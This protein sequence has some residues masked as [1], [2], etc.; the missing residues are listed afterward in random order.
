MG[1]RYLCWLCAGMI[2]VVWLLYCMGGERV[3]PELRPSVSEENFREREGVEVQGR[4]SDKAEKNGAFTIRLKDVIFNGKLVSKEEIIVYFEEGSLSRVPE[5][6]EDI[7]VSGKIRF[8]QEP[9]NPGNFNQKFYYQKQNIHAS[10]YKAKLEGGIGKSSDIVSWVKEKL[11]KIRRAAVL[12]AVKHMGQEKGGLLCAMLVGERGLVD[13]ELSVLYQRSQIAHLFTVSGLHVSFFG[14]GLYKILRKMGLPIVLCAVTASVCLSAYVILVGAGVSAVRALVMF[15]MRMGAQISGRVYDG[16]TSLSMAAIVTLFRQPLV[17]W[18]A[19]FLL[20]FGAV[21]GIY[22]ILPFFQSE[23]E[24]KEESKQ[25][26]ILK[27]GMLTALGVNGMIL[28]MTLYFYYEFAPYS[29]LWN[30]PVIAVS[31][32]VLGTGFM[33]TVFGMLAGGRGKIFGWMAS[34][35]FKVTDAGFQFYE[36]GSRLLLELPGSHMIVGQPKL[37]QIV[38]YYV[39]LGIAL[40]IV[41]KRTE[42]RRTAVRTLPIILLAMCILFFPQEKKGQ[43][44]VTMLD[45]GQGDCFFIRGPENTTYLIDGG[46][47]SVSKVGKYRIESFLKSKGIG[48]LDY[49]FVSHGD[50]DHISGVEELLA[51]QSMGIQV[52]NLVLPTEEVWDTSLKRLAIQALDAGTSVRVIEQG[53]HIQ[54]QEL[55]LTCLWPG[56]NYEGETGNAA[57][58]VLGLSYKEF[59]MIFMGDI[60]KEAE[61]GLADWMKRNK[62]KCPQRYEVLKA[63]HHG[64]KSS[65]SE[66]LLEQVMPL[67]VFFSA[68]QGNSYGHPHKEVVEKLAKRG[69]TLYNTKE[70][71]AVCLI[72][73]GQDTYINLPMQK[74]RNIVY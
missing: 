10:I 2:A 36:I 55:I 18:D 49:I 47:S 4:I 32:Y 45:V 43:L 72:T 29:L 68:G 16:L 40:I 28:P 30:M 71:G 21:L 6:G 7:L 37:R 24:E 74:R 54:E 63:G 9:R 31:S 53:E 57:S 38:S 13:E 27:E 3:F 42:K 14:M 56:E 48:R 35:F 62:E 5:M 15:Y 50:G 26:R 12:T 65:S 73:D 20:S 59:D 58:M 46:S 1:K 70:Q 19:S 22:G 17:L 64:S 11:W 51:A 8:Y 25:K 52:G 39:L 60:E 33:G 69:C 66:E 34:L 44:E 67:A 23:R 61:K 41:S